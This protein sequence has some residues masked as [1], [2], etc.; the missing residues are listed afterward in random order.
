MSGKPDLFNMYS[1]LYVGRFEDL[2][3]LSFVRRIM[4]N[5]A[6]TGL[7]VRPAQCYIYRSRAQPPNLLARSA[8]HALLGPGVGR[9]RGGVFLHSVDCTN[10]IMRTP[11][12]GG[13]RTGSAS[14]SLS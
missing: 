11:E 14:R 10:L 3:L 2:S 4:C 8:A 9:A 1:E 6:K 5:S 7:S 12:A 13:V